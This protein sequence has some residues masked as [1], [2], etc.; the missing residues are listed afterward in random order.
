MKFKLL[1]A[2]IV[3][4]GIGGLVFARLQA[5][6]VHDEATHPAHAVTVYKTPTC[7]CCTVYANYLRAKNYDV[8]TVD[9]E[10]EELADKHKSLGVPAALTSCHTTVSKATGQ[11]V[12]GHIP[13]EAINQMLDET[14]DAKG[15][16]M[17]GMPSGSPGMP[18]NKS[19]PFNISLVDDEGVV[20]PYL[21]L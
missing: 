19:E 5:P 18:G 15:I 6:P 7:G 13:F 14:P 17:P 2:A 1:F 16:G 10:A 4:V 20:S 9:L 11:F 3:V 8:E 21:T 12:E